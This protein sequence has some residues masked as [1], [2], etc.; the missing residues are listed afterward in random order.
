[1][2]GEKKRKVICP[3]TG[4]EIGRMEET[5]LAKVP[6][7]YEKARQAFPAWAEMPVKKRV[8]HLRSLRLYMLEHME[9]LVQVITDSTGKVAVEALTAD[10]LTVVDAVQHMEK[11]AASALAP[12]RVSTPLLFFGKKSYI[13]YKPRGVVLVISP[14]NYPFQLAMI[15]VVSALAAGNTVILKPS[16]VTP[17]VGKWIET[18]FHESGFPEGVVQVA[19]GGKELGAGLVERKPDYIFFTGSVRTG[20][21]IQEQAARYLIPTTL[22]LG[23]KDPM[24][25]FGDAH[26]ERAVKGAVWGGLTNSGQVCMS[27]ERLYVEKPVYDRFVRQLVKEVNRLQQGRGTDDDLGSMTFPGQIDIVREHIEDAL[28]RGARL[29]TGQEPSRWNMDNGMFLEPMVLV[30]VTPDMKVMREESFGPILPVMPF[31]GEDEAV[32]L[33]NDSPYGLNASVWSRDLEKAKRIASRLVS[34]NVVINDVMITVAN[35]HL[36]FGG[37]KE[38]GIGRYHGDV[39]LQTFCHQ[40]SVMVDPGKSASEVNWFPYRG[41]YPLFLQLIRSYFGEKKA[42]WRFIKSYLHLLRK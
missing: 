21:I 31:E 18:L 1:M 11:T 37:V 30:D 35:P 16:E 22:E 32:R 36:P 7:M 6:L 20:K 29:L 19:H 13:E 12:R 27:V 38:S 5:P 42:W 10:I 28:A 40:T 25:V 24:I 33:A 23:G 14:W 3:A 26:L 9:E 34:G 17:L 4:E 15:P 8:E 41:K 39:G 2:T